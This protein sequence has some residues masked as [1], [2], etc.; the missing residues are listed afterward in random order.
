[1][2]M[3]KPERLHV[4]AQSSVLGLMVGTML[5]IPRATPGPGV[6]L[7]LCSIAADLWQPTGDKV[8]AG[9]YV[10][11]VSLSLAALTLYALASTTWAANPALA[12]QSSLQLAALGVATIYLCEAVPRRIAGLVAGDRALYVRAIPIAFGIG[13]VILAVDFSSRHSIMLAVLS[14]FPGLAGSGRKGL[15]ASGS[16]FTWMHS[17]YV[18]QNI[19]ALVL[20]MQPTLAAA[21]LWLPE[22]WRRTVIWSSAALM[23][24]VVLMSDSETAKLAAIVSL[25]VSLAAARWPQR[26]ATA[27]AVV[28]SLGL[29]LAPVLGRLP[30]MAGL[31][32]APWVTIGVR[33]R[34]LI[35]DATARTSL[36]SPILGIGMQ[37]TRF[38]EARLGRD[39]A[40]TP[41][42][43]AGSQARMPTSQLG[44]HSHNAYLQAWLELGVIGVLILLALGLALIRNAAQSPAAIRPAALGLAAAALT[45][46][47]TGWGMW[48]P[49]LLASVAAATLC[50][51]IAI[52]EAI[53]RGADLP[54]GLQPAS[55]STS[56]PKR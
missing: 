43:A 44:W 25:A 22:R 26:A 40:G 38:T 23:L 24:V 28:F 7:A 37:S 30:A 8:D 29:L 54:A 5:L 41:D 53:A 9:R 56:G 12:L 48:Q 51:K 39:G 4:L 1:M 10:G 27:M 17:F 14:A 42:A 21:G 13:L 33:D 15:V 19:A 55:A 46:A 18:N 3:L 50:L 32:K 11:P 2:A 47:A 35:W 45:I 16:T 20:L 31:D 6:L 36:Q 34:V 52:T 49:W